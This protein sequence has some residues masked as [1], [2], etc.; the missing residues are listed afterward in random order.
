M[1]DSQSYAAAGRFT[2]GPITPT[3]A[4]FALPLLVTNL[5][6]S[7]T[8]TWGAVWVGRTIGPDAL[9]AVATA[10]VLMYMVMGSA[11]GIGTAAGVA[12]GQS[13]GARDISA[14]KRVVG[15]AIAFIIGLSL[16]L[17]GL[18]WALTP[19][20]VDGMGVP[21]ASRSYAIT[22]LRMTCLT[23]PSIFTYMVMMMMLRSSG[24]ARTPFRF[25]LVWII[26]AVLLTPLLVSGTGM[27]GGS[28]W[29]GFGMAGLGL[30]HL[31]ANGAALG[32][33][34]AYIYLKRSP[35]ALHGDDLR[36]LQ[37]DPVLL[38]LLVKRGLPM[39]AESIIVQGAYF[40][41]LAMVN[42]YGA[43]TAAAYAASAQLWA[44]VQ[45]PS[46][47]LAA[48]MSAMAAMNI[49]AG[50]WDRVSQIARRGCVLSFGISSAV[51]VAMLAAGTLPLQLFV[52]RDAAVLA[53][54]L[55][56][57]H[58]VLWG[59][60]ALSVTMGLFAVMRANGAML[61]P[62]L[63]F[64]A[65]MWAGR[66]PFAHALQPWLGADAIWWSFPFGSILSALV[67]WAWY[68]RGSWRRN[69]PMLAPLD[70]QYDE[71]RLGE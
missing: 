2:S 3:L 47:A 32:L 39:A 64:A 20:V 36:H 56:I 17:A 70:S 30:A 68:R 42:A 62:T 18:G 29:A 15:C 23:M 46:N 34:V 28:G 69:R 24:D 52:P 44:F 58:I 61:A 31:L 55:H 16:L 8:G 13:L 12:I 33:M 53:Q 7:L 54:A 65:T 71:G 41:L 49:G 37:P 4:R 45:L 50:R 21:A 63:I 10:T 35:I 51:T 38:V 66:V 48:A 9:T 67:A 25:T 43:A 14:V 19:F 27:W 59:W 1:S 11:M 57:N 40:T 5:L 60:I 26:G 6:H 22:H